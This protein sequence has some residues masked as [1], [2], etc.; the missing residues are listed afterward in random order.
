MARD[1]PERVL[2]TGRHAGFEYAL[3]HNWTAHWL[4]YVRL[5]AGHP[6]NNWRSEEPEIECHGGITWHADDDAGHGEWV[7]WDYA[8][9][10]DLPDPA[11]RA[12]LPPEWLALLDRL[13]VPE[14]CMGDEKTWT[15][16]EVRAEAQGVCDQANAAMTAAGPATVG[17]MLARAVLNG[18]HAAVWP[19]VD[20]LL[21]HRLRPE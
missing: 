5:P 6:W 20:W 16:D 1:E 15:I 18:D 17:E 12:R 19:L 2:A 21:E 14:L 9:S 3:L 8:H 10:W 7:G 13:F 4:A 11:L